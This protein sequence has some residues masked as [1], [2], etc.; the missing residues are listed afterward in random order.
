MSGINAFTHSVAEIS[1]S[2]VRN[3]KKHV[4]GETEGGSQDQQQIEEPKVP[5]I[6]QLGLAPASLD[7]TASFECLNSEM[8]FNVYSLEKDSFSS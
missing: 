6:P 8:N 5:L 4:Q 3:R 1:S 2:L 7:L